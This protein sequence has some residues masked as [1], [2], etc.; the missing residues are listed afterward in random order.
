MLAPQSQ[1]PLSL[2]APTQDSSGADA[3]KEASATQEGHLQL[4]AVQQAVISDD[5][6]ALQGGGTTDRSGPAAD[7]VAPVVIDA[8][9]ADGGVDDPD[10]TPPEIIAETADCDSD[11]KQLGGGA[12]G[13]GLD[14][15]HFSGGRSVS[16]GGNLQHTVADKVVDER[17]CGAECATSIEP[18]KMTTV[19]QAETAE[20]LD[21]HDLAVQQA[22]PVDSAE[23]DTETR[24]GSTPASQPQTAASP[25]LVAESMVAAA[26][27]LAALRH[28]AN[29]DDGGVVSPGSG[30]KTV[31]THRGGYCGPT[32]EEVRELQIAPTPAVLPHPVANPSAAAKVAPRRETAAAAVA[33]C[34]GELRAAIGSGAW[35]DMDLPGLASVQQQLARLLA[36]VSNRLADRINTSALGK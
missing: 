18:T 21:R 36:D 30:E 31:E 13:I 6:P 2:A 26:E 22:R 12:A 7:K 5:R 35:D 10:G 29:V 4:D 14:P 34:L 11:G 1:G 24:T 15:G 8:D 25:S 16:A 19:G 27:T 23:P 9:D 3:H 32:D 28:E 17:N 33:E 20:T